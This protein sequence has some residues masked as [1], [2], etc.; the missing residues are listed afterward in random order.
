V[1]WPPAFADEEHL[2]RSRHLHPGCA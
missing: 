2:H 1:Q